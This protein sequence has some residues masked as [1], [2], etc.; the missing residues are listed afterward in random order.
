VFAAEVWQRE[1]EI[2]EMDCIDFYLHSLKEMQSV[3]K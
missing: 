1:M 3:D 2:S